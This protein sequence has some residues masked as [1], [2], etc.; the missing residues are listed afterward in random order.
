M[1]E[2]FLEISGSLSNAV[3]DV[4]VRNQFLYNTIIVAYGLILAVAHNNLRIV[5]GLLK[6]RYK[7]KDWP[8]I[9][10]EVAHDT[11][12]NLEATIKKRLRIPVVASPYFFTLYRI[13]RKNLVTVLGKKH[14]VPRE[15]LKELLMT[16]MRG[17]ARQQG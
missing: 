10:Y 4:Y 16:S 11:D 8:E 9:L 7:D 1:A 2:L 5:E 13:G 15:T 3:L 17:S 12:A 6:A 14:A